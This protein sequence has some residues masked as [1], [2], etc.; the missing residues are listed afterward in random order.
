MLKHFAYD[1]LMAGKGLNAC[2]DCD[3]VAY[4]TPLIIIIMEIC[5]ACSKY[6]LTYIMYIE[7]NNFISNLTK[8]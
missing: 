2:Q 3:S 4:G 1:A 6:N 8:S 5:R 7:M